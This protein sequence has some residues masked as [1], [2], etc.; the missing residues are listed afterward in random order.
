MDVKTEE[1]SNTAKRERMCC[2]WTEISR[3]S[4]FL[5]FL[6]LFSESPELPLTS[7]GKMPLSYSSVTVYVD[8]VKGCMKNAGVA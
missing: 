6:Y 5:R 3:N 7:E 2:V 4:E 1:R 8:A